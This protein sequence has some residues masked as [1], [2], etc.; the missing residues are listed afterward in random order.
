[1]AQRSSHAQPG[2]DS[3]QAAACDTA[4]SRMIPR[5]IRERG[6]VAATR[7]RQPDDVAVHHLGGALYRTSHRPRLAVSH[8]RLLPGFFEASTAC[9][10]TLLD[11]GAGTPDSLD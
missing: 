9:H 5:V 1:M 3:L 7:A 10:P 2:F 11:A 8:L 6:M 4:S